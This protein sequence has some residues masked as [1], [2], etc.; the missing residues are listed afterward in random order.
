MIKIW[1]RRDLR[2]DFAR[3]GAP[4]GVRTASTTEFAVP[5]HLIPAIPEELLAGALM[6][7]QPYVASAP[8]PETTRGDTEQE[9]APPTGDDQPP[10]PPAGD[11]PVP[12][13]L[14][15]IVEGLVDDGM[16]TETPART[17]APPAPRSRTARRARA[18]EGR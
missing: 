1:P 17:A 18:G 5:D 7:G 15:A 13:G 2:R 10:T 9:Q 12:D 8:A 16:V 3:W 4:L 6:D 14:D 11:G